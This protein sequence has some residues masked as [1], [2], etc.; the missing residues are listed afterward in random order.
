MPESESRK[1]WNLRGPSRLRSRRISRV[2][3]S[4]TTSRERATGQN[5]S[6]RLVFIS[7]SF[8]NDLDRHCGLSGDGSKYIN[9]S[10]YYLWSDRH[11]EATIT[12]RNSL[13][14]FA[15]ARIEG[16]RRD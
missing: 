14:A 9:N 5:R 7:A 6:G 12:G 11:D 1:S 3:R 4:P 10:H 16:V 2:Q 15:A 8:S 13:A